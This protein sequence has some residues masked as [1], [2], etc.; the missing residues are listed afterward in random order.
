MRLPRA[1]SRDTE[2]TFRD[3]ASGTW[4]RKAVHK[5]ENLPDLELNLLR[6]AQTGPAKNRVLLKPLVIAL[7]KVIAEVGPPA[8]CACQSGM[9]NRLRHVA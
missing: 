3:P 7:G 1:V 8:L 6:P 2:A 5:A 4:I 9:Q